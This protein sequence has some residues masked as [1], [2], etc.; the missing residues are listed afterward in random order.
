VYCIN[1]V[2]RTNPLYPIRKKKKEK[3][4]KKNTKASHLNGRIDHIRM[5]GPVRLKREKG[6][7]GRQF[8]YCLAHLHFDISAKTIAP[9]FHPIPV[10]PKLDTN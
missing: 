1:L 5:I 10:K 7:D 8:P 2:A 9:H 4:K 3:K 6:T